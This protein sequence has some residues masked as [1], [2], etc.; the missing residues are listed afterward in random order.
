MV[1][2]YMIGIAGFTNHRAVLQRG[3]VRYSRALANSTGPEINYIH[4]CVVI[5]PR[6]CNGSTKLRTETGLPD[7]P[8]NIL[9]NQC[10][11]RL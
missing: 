2:Y 4:K 1:S 8:I 9:A 6:K 7:A 11:T 3:L 10:G 5:F